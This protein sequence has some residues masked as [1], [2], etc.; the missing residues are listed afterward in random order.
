MADGWDAEQAA[1]KKILGQKG[2]LPKPPPA[3][4]NGRTAIEKAATAFT[5][6]STVF[7]GKLEALQE[8]SSNL[9]NAG[10]QFQS[11]IAKEDFGL[12]PKDADDKK[13]IDEARKNLDAYFSNGNKKMT[14]NIKTLAEF[15]KHLD[16]MADYKS[17]A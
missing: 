11:Q 6:A 7:T 15:E 10:S 3:F 14:T 5:T 16:Q 1:V 17:P 8:A 13:K 9:L 2:K 4:I 12:D